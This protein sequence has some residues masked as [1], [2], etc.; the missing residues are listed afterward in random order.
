MTPAGGGHS[1]DG[2]RGADPRRR[3]PAPAEADELGPL[4]RRRVGEHRL[5]RGRDGRNVG[6]RG[7]VGRR[8][9]RRPAH[10]DDD[11]RDRCGG[12]PDR[13]DHAAPWPPDRPAARAR[14]RDPR[15]RHRVRLDPRRLDPAA[16]P[17]QRLHRLRQR[18]REPRPL[19]R[20]RHGDAGT[21][22]VGPRPGRVGHDD[23]RGHRSEPGGSRRRDGRRPWLP[24]ARRVVPA[25]GLLHRPGLDRVRVPAAPGAV[26]AGRSVGPAR[27]GRPAREGAGAASD[28]R[29][30]LGGRGAR[31]AGRR[32]GRDGP[33]HDD[34]PD[35]PH[36]PRAWPRDRRPG[37]LGAHVRDV[38][39]LADHREADR[40]V[41]Q[42]AA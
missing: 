15:R 2:D 9:A 14:G 4:H 37:P 38:R 18:G 42:P 24:R 13:D 6:R 29:A 20:R 30:S 28:R 26:C 34:D 16:A 33:D 1:G 3:P 27:S 10:D 23:R 41:R 8:G 40:S 21:T 35:P 11:D 5:H 32:P 22:C 17:R 39:A 7:D 25:D 36:G 19:H 31:D 12:E